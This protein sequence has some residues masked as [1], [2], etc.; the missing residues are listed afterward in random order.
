MKGPFDSEPA[1][2]YAASSQGPRASGNSISLFETT[3]HAQSESTR[4]AQCLPPSGD[5]IVSP[6]IVLSRLRRPYSSMSSPVNLYL[7]KQFTQVDVLIEGNC[8]SKV[9]I[10]RRLH[11]YLAA[12]VKHAC[13]H[14]LHLVRAWTLSPRPWESGLTYQRLPLRERTTENIT[15]ISHGHMFSC[16]QFSFKRVVTMSLRPVTPTCEGWR[17]V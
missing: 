9:H 12:R 17:Y 8:L 11:G 10:P 16:A 3:I 1:S 2:A 14:R 7:F 4:S 5:C 13:E 6:S 15:L